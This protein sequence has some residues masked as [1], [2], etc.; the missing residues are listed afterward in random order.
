MPCTWLQKVDTLRS[1]NSCCLSLEKGSM[2]RQIAPIP[3][4]TGQSGRVTV[5]WHIT[6]FKIYKWTRRIG[7]RCVGCQGTVVSK[8]KVYMCAWFSLCSEACCDKT[9]VTWTSLCT[10][11]CYAFRVLSHSS[12]LVIVLVMHHQCIVFTSFSQPVIAGCCRIDM[13]NI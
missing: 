1:S 10:I 5:R 12:L 11:L 3:C 2:R 7:T 9:G 13:C 4:C 8:C 6:S